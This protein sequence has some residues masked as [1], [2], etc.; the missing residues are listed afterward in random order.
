MS[1][2]KEIVRRLLLT[3]G[4]AAALAGLATAVVVLVAGDPNDKEGAG[5][6]LIAAVAGFWAWRLL[7][8]WILLYSPPPREPSSF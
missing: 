4:G 3:I 1:N 7:I 2:G 6:G 5:W 8:N